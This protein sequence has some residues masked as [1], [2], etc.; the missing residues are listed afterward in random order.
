M[1]RLTKQQ[2]KEKI[3]KTYSKVFGLEEMMHVCS[4]KVIVTEANV[5]CNIL[6]YRP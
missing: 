2:R 3:A 1:S 4:P 5:S 6:E